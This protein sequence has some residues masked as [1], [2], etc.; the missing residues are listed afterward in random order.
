LATGAAL[1]GSGAAAK[2]ISTPGVA[3]AAVPTSAWK[4]LAGELDGKLLRP[5]DDGFARAASTFD[6][7]RDGK[8][9]VAIVRAASA[10][11]VAAAFAFCRSHGVHP[12]PR[13]GGHSYVGASTGN[14][15][16]VIDVRPM[17]GVHYHAENHKVTVGA[18]AVLGDLHQSLDRHGR[19]VPTGTCP[20]VGAAGLTL[21]GGI[22]TESRLYGLTADALTGGTLVSPSGHIH[23]FG[24]HTD[25]DLF[26][27]L[28]GGG[29]G[30]FGVVTSLTYATSPALPGTIFRLSW[31]HH[32]NHRVLM[33]WQERLAHLP[34]HS[35]ANLH[36]DTAGGVV[37][38]SITGVCWDR[39]ASREI[40][41]MVD[42][43]GRE[44]LSRRTYAE[45]HAGAMGWFAGGANGRT[46]QSWYAGSDVVG[47]AITSARA[48]DII[49]AVRKWN[50]SGA[51]AAIFDPLGGAVSDLGAADTAF[52][53]RHANATVQWYVGL[54][55]TSRANVGR[56]T[57]WVAGC[58]HAI[59]RSSVGGYL[60]YLEPGRKL[61]DYSGDNYD[62]LLSLNTKYDPHGIL[63]S[64]YSLPG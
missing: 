2:I 31:G 8:R 39:G 18:G 22:G 64:R 55:S 32:D 40:K 1:F 42:A 34:R 61:S 36:L 60:N 51:A 14:G 27:G 29:G 56:A 35:W 16:L 50:G 20:T 4:H 54:S 53:W 44:P 57:D 23:R 52:R 21:G 45:S 26:W 5:G 17:H 43:I 7:R 46:R 11:D 33:G 3:D 63:N 24:R 41:A 47:H 37:S 62:R 12:R 19:T 13:S 15:V 6:P 10:G 58:H 9:P 25:A 30:N 59:G 48:K 38:P 49:A 28:R